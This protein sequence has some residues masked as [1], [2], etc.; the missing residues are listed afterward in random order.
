MRYVWGY[1]G[2][3]LFWGILA[4]GATFGDYFGLVILGR[5]TTFWEC[6]TFGQAGLLWGRLLLAWEAYFWD[7]GN[8]AGGLHCLKEGPKGKVGGLDHILKGVGLHLLKE[9]GSTFLKNRDYIS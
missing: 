6:A 4:G 1:L 5:P 3:G 8:W 9:E 2:G 7:G